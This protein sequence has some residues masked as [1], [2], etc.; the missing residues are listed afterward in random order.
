MYHFHGLTLRP[1]RRWPPTRQ[2][3]VFSCQNLESGVKFTW[4]FFY[5]WI[6]LTPLPPPMC[7]CG[8]SSPKPICFS[9][10]QPSIAI[11]HPS[12]KAN[13]TCALVPWARALNFCLHSLFAIPFH[14]FCHIFLFGIFYIFFSNCFNA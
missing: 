12:A 4:A 7:V 1:H 8:P 2:R 11:I 9:C 10:L 13:A 3:K 14:Y 5:I 6:W